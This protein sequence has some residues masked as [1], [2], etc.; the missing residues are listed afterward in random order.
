MN[1]EKIGIYIHIP[2][3][4]RKCAYCDF[5]SF[6]KLE[7]SYM[8]IYA[9]ELIKRISSFAKEKGTLLKADTVYFGGGTPTLLPGECFEDIFEALRTYFVLDA[10]SEITVECNPASIDREGLK[11]LFDMGVNRLSIGLQSANASELS[12]LGR[13]HNYEEFCDTYRAAREIGFKNISVDLMYGLPEQTRESFDRT[14]SEVIALSPEHISAY[15]LKIEEG[16]DFYLRGDSLK[17]PSED[18]VAEQYE[19]C[20]ERLSANG[21]ER[22]EIS[23]FSKPDMRSRHNLKYWRLCDYIG[24]G[25]SAYSFIDG[26]RFGCSRDICAFL[27]GENIEIERYRPSREECADEYIML[28]MRLSEGISLEKYARMTGVDIMR[29]HPEIELFIKNGF[30]TEDNGR[31]AFT[32]KGFLVSNEILSK[33]LSFEY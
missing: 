26:E 11:S 1:K 10:D 21:Y 13:L 33:I 19:L 15:A 2:F 8:Q 30:M 7:K 4:I 23:N 29:E 25:I 6:D 22:Y 3:C 31:L 5:C 32:T 14:L 9:K 28:G 12:I 16:T 18:A 24:F 27:R 20:C 17:L